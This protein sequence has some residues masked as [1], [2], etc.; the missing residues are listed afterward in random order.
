MLPREHTCRLFVACH[1]NA[2]SALPVL[3][4]YHREAA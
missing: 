1:A 3:N 4:F 2:H